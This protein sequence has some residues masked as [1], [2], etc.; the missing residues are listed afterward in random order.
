MYNPLENL[1]R[2]ISQSGGFFNAHAHLD[3]AFT[4]TEMDMILTKQPLMKKWELV[5]EVKKNSSEEDY[6]QRICYALRTQ[7]EKGVSSV[8]TFV[9]I[10]PIVE[11]R[12]IRG[13]VRAKKFAKEIGMELS[14][15]SQTLKG[16]I[17]NY[18]RRLLEKCLT[19]GW[20]DVIGS[21][22]KADKDTDRHL[23]T[24]CSMA[25]AAQLPLHVHVDQNNNPTEK[26][27][28]Q[29]ARKTIQFGIEGR[30]TAVHCISL[31]THPKNYRQKVYNLAKD[32]GLMFVA[33]PTAWLDHPRNETLMPFH[34][35]LT[36]VDELI[37]NGLVVGIGS[38]NIHDI[39]KPFCDGDMLT[40]LRVLLEGCKIYDSEELFCIATENGRK[41]IKKTLR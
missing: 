24:V 30:V 33:C 21:L 5:D 2:R 12:A 8:T 9:D 19:E 26:E 7:Q 23:D 3:R 18:S 34:N 17:P 25:R 1:R 31:A 36:P 22:P 4:V 27:T 37:A 14:L 6:Y 10:D 39:Y 11:Y 41:T 38:D 13:A 15:A 20:L 29:L 40:E 32:S 16:V 28:E 35:A